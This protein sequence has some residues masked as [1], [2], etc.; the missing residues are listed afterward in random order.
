MSDTVRI[1]TTVTGELRDRVEAWR[2]AQYKKNGSIPELTEAARILMHKGL[3]AD[4][5]NI[6]SREQK[7]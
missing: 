3:V 6:N 1:N 7:S 5:F 4:G 2:A